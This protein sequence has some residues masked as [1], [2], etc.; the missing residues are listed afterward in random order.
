MRRCLAYFNFGRALLLTARPSEGVVGIDIELIND[1]HDINSYSEFIIR[2]IGDYIE[3]THALLVQWD[4]FIIHPEMWHPDFLTYDYIGAT[5][6]ASNTRPEAVGNGGFSLRSKK[7][8]NT[9]QTIKFKQYHPEDE[10]IARTHRA[11]LEAEGIRFAPPEIG[12]QFAYEFKIPKRPTFGFHGFSNFPDFMTTAEL[13]SFV[14]NM[15]S[16]LSF[17]NYFLEFARKVFLRAEEK[18]SRS[19]L[20]TLL[21]QKIIADI[22]N[23]QKNRLIAEHTKHLISGLCR[24]RLGSIAR[25]LAFARVAAAPNP[26]NIRLLAKTFFAR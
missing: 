8:L 25:S 23:A 6:P 20:A 19:H 18:A 9:L 21:R 15:P 7:L 26:K 13:K 5:W 2:R 11:K 12:D 24:L 14:A 10:M 4:G 17:N 1:V 16:G 22:Q 3:T